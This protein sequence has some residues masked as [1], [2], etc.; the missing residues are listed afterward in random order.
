MNSSPHFFSGRLEVYI[1][2]T[3]STVCADGWGINETNVAC[4]QMGFAR[5]THR[6]WPINEPS[7]QP[8][9][10][11]KVQCLGGESQLTD[12]KH[13]N[14]EIHDCDHYKDVGIVC[15]NFSLGELHIIY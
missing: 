15:T 13:N 8:I 1:N 2:R 14:F 5:G 12:C 11:D 10:L 7:T 9:W 3:W 6:V 4:R